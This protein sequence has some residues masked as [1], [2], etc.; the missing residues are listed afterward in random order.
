MTTLNIG[1]SAPP[2][3]LPTLSD[4]TTAMPLSKE[5]FSLILFVKRECPTCRMT[6]PFFGRLVKAYGDKVSFSIVTENE[7]SDGEEVARLAGVSGEMVQLEPEPW[8]TS[9]AYGIF[10]VPV[11]FEV[12]ADKKVAR[13]VLGWNRAAYEDLNERLSQFTGRPIIELITEADGKIP[14]VKPG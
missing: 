6:L 8:S 9:T 11:L 12:S 2:F 7:A 10:S 3:S 1:D 14:S 5:P 4:S 13:S